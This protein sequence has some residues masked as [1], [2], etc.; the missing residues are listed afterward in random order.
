MGPP[1]IGSP[2]RYP[3]TACPQRR[4]ARLAT[5]TA[6]G[7]NAR[8]S[9]VVGSIDSMDD[10]GGRRRDALAA[11]LRRLRAGP[12]TIAARDHAVLVEPALERAVEEH[13]LPRRVQAD[14]AWQLRIA[15]EDERGPA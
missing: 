7:T 10:R 15:G 13:G 4:A 3:E 8:R 9:S 14:E 1:I 11:R 12:G 6:A 2:P 5:H